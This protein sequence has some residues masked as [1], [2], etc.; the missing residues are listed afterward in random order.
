MNTIFNVGSP[1]LIDRVFRTNP[2][3]P[4]T[5]VGI[6][7]GISLLELLVMLPIETVR[8]RLQCQIRPDRIKGHFETIVPVSQIYYSSVWDCVYS[9]ATREGRSKPIIR[10]FY[11]GVKVRFLLNVFDAVLL[12]LR[13]D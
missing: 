12:L 5:F 11:R 4:W 2:D 1:L 10:E 3:Y 8:H 7:L 13:T 9:I 6:E